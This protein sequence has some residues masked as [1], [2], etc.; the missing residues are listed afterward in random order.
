MTAGTEALSRASRR[1]NQPSLDPRCAVFDVGNA[2]C[3][4]SHDCFRVNHVK[5]HLLLIS[6]CNVSFTS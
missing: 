5:N 1:F 6:Q 3:Q 4:D 2:H